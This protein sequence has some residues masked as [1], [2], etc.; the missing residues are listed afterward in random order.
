MFIDRDALSLKS[1]IDDI[2]DLATEYKVPIGASDATTVHQGASFGYGETGHVYASIAASQAVRCLL[3]NTGSVSNIS[4][5]DVIEQSEMCINHVATMR[6]G[7][8]FNEIMNTAIRMRSIDKEY[9]KI[10]ESI[11]SGLSIEE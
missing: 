8:S 7:V 1:E 4:P 2:L 6:Q 11:Y 9:D 5:Q 3:A 10:Q